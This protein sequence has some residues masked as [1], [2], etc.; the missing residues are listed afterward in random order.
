MKGKAPIESLTWLLALID[1]TD[2][3]V[4]SARFDGRVRTWNTAAERMY[5]YRA[6]EVIGRPA[7]MLAP[8]EQADDFVE[9]LARVARG[10]AVER[11][12]TV[13]LRKNGERFEALISL[14]PMRG[15]DGEI[16]GAAVLSRDLSVER[17]YEDARRQARRLEDL[18][19]LAGGVVHDFNNLLTAILTS[20]SLALEDA[21]GSSLEMIQEMVEA[22]ARASDLSRQLLAYARRAPQSPQLVDLDSVVRGVTGVL[23]RLVAG[24]VELVVATGEQPLPAVEIDLTQAQ[25]V[26]VNL[27]LNARDAMPGGGVVTVSTSVANNEVLLAVADSGIGI[28]EET[29]EHM[30][31]PFFTTKEADRGTG[32]GLAN[33]RD[34]VEQAGG[35]IEVASSPGNGAVFTVRLPVAAAN[36]DASLHVAA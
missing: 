16:V 30:F 26:I 23:G 6:D 29:R 35:R 14:H 12:Q 3:A 10:E 8:P 17:E 36:S 2:M 33:V 19:R 18:G 5:G 13:R 4:G 22:A 32:L 25:Q 21:T 1:T 27:V 20:G 28:D 34:I 24:Q 7:S 15:D 9:L 11:H 31:E